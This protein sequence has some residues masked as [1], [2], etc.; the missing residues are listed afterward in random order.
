[1]G[2]TVHLGW[3]GHSLEEGWICGKRLDAGLGDK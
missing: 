1:M 2:E 3:A